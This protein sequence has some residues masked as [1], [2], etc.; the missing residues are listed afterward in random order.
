[1]KI[2]IVFEFENDQPL[3]EI[4]NRI[5][6]IHSEI[7]PDIIILDGP[8][9]SE[10]L[11]ER[12]RTRGIRCILGNPDDCRRIDQLLNPGIEGFKP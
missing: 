7:K 12:L 6:E 5:L 4:E 11:L 8:Q 3:F 1:M 9:H 2:I 10:Y